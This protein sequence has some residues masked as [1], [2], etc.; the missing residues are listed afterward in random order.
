MTTQT[1]E[2]DPALLINK[3]IRPI[4]NWH[5]WLQMWKNTDTLEQLIGLLHC[6]MNVSMDR[7]SSDPKKYEFS[8]RYI[9]YFKVANQWKHPIYADDEGRVANNRFVATTKDGQ[10]VHMDVGAARRMIAEKAFEMLCSHYFKFAL[11][12]ESHTGRRQR[13]QSKIIDVSTFQVLMDFF[14]RDGKVENIPSEQNHTRKVTVDFLLELVQFV[15][16]WEEEPCYSHDEESYKKA[17]QERVIIIGN[18]RIWSLH[19]LNHLGKLSSLKEHF[20]KLSKPVITELKVIARR[21][22][23]DFDDGEGHRNAK[24]ID[25][26]CYAGS[27]AALLLK[28]YELW[29]REHQRLKQ[30]RE[31]KEK[32]QAVQAR[33]RKLTSVK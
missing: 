9:F 31:A 2:A 19:I 32:A 14:M 28:R 33:L 6:G 4:G 20:T 22:E 7:F 18:A 30:I 15:W 23:M 24:T 26:A 1:V 3:K 5:E 16:S 25:E 17:V 12:A 21:V 8:D 11:S 13:F 10:L 27:A 29:T